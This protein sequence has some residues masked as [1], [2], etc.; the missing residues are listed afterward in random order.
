MNGPWRARLA[1]NF[2][3]A[4]GARLI[5]RAPRVRAPADRCF[6]VIGA[7]LAVIGVA[8]GAYGTPI[9]VDPSATGERCSDARSAVEASFPD[10]PLCSAERALAVAGGGDAVILREGSYPQLKVEDFS[11][12]SYVT[13]R[14]F[15][16]E[17]VTVRGVAMEDTD[18]L[19][20][21][22]LRITKGVSIEGGH[23]VALVGNDIGDYRNGVLLVAEEGSPIQRV[24]IE[25]NRVHDIDYPEPIAEDG[26][27]GYGIRMLGPVR[28]TTIRSNRIERV[29]ED[30][31]QGGEAGITVE[32]NHFNGPSLRFDN[33]DEVH[34]DLW[35]IYYP[36]RNIVF[37]DNIARKT[38]VQTGL[39]FQF[40]DQG[41]AHR[42][43]VIENNLLDR[44]SDGAAM[45]IYN[46]R[47]LSIANNTVV[48]SR[49]GT[50][51]RYDDRAPEGRD[52]RIVNN[53]FGAQTG[54]ALSLEGDWGVES[55]NLL[56]SLGGLPRE[57]FAS[58]DVVGREPEFTDPDAG[59]FELTEDSPGIDAGT[60][61]DVPRA[62]LRGAERD[63]RPDI[64]AFERSTPSD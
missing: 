21:E 1:W 49:Q 23:D 38:G 54:S 44:V 63:G 58:T 52:Y 34:S 4:A 3:R 10:R 2:N 7:L 12:G 30:Y 48:G 42:N 62:D 56:V 35:Q 16:T 28:N 14:A 36:A 6:D 17:K 20:V 46:T 39:L 41:P 15:P 5:A 33:S 13:V 43:V 53:I 27:S 64:G 9:Y 57:D 11:P 47:G 22:G 31:I 60:A 37:R 18:H 51:L 29:L 24:L 19:R 45:Q 26:L 50:L 59:D 55:H 40:S 32:G 61:D 25:G 8:A